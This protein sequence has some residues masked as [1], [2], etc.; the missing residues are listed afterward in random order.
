MLFFLLLQ[1]V[2]ISNG[3]IHLQDNFANKLKINIL[4]EETFYNAADES[5]RV[6]CVEQIFNSDQC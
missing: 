3:Q 6:L 2:Y 5:Y 1:T 4:F